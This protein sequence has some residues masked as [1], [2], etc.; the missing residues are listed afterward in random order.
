MAT[1]LQHRR[2]ALRQFPVLVNGESKPVRFKAPDTEEARSF[3]QDCIELWK[4]WRDR[5]LDQTG[6][7]LPKKKPSVSAPADALSQVL[8]N[9]GGP[10]DVFHA[11][12]LAT[13][14]NWAHVQ[15]KD[16]TSAAPRWV[17]AFLR[18]VY[19]SR[20]RSPVYLQ[21]KL[22]WQLREEL[23]QKIT[24]TLDMDFQFWDGISE[25]PEPLEVEEP[26]QEDVEHV[27]TVGS[28]LAVQ[29]L[30]VGMEE[31]ARRQNDIIVKATMI[32][33]FGAIRSVHGRLVM[34]P[35]V[36]EALKMFLQVRNFSRPQRLKY[37]PRLC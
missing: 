14:V 5:A 23:R 37:K 26:Q 9:T 34:L 25:Q 7:K 2:L 18:A 36:K 21:N 13:S 19:F 12:M 35:E 27:H 8:D 24:E 33:N 20:E 15:A 29:N 4:A 32:E 6:R 1:I 17:D 28:Q 3:R 11:T 16:V 30:V 10:G 31:V 22:V